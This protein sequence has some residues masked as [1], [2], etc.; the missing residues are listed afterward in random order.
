M[1]RRRQKRRRKFNSGGNLKRLIKAC[2]RKMANV[3]PALVTVSLVAGVFF[4]IR[5]SLYADSNLAIQRVVIS[6]SDRLSPW[7]RQHLD[8]QLLNRNI[9][10]V[11]LKRVARELKKNPDVLRVRVM[12]ELPSTV[13]VEVDGRDPMLFVQ[14]SPNGPYGIA[15]ED[16][17]ILDVVKERD[18]SLVLLRA[19]GSNQTKPIV[20]RRPKVRGLRDAIEF[21]KEFRKAPLARRETITHMSLDRLGNATMTLNGGPEV[22]LGRNPSERIRIMSHIIPILEGQSRSK[23]DY[24]DLQFDQV[25]VKRRGS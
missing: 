12:R 25:V 13:R 7:Q 11:D 10:K 1:V 15:S 24:I 16:G 8:T 9:L 3:M 17:M 20:G 23:I 2:T 6:P 5:T 19:Y 4:G 18:A 22:R 21:I 14:L